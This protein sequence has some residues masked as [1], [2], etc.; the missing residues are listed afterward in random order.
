MNLNREIIDCEMKN[1]YTF[2]S[3][4]ALILADILDV[5][6]NQSPYSKGLSTSRRI[7]VASKNKQ[8]SMVG[9]SRKLANRTGLFLAI[10][11]VGLIVTI[12]VAG[13]SDGPLVPAVP[14][15]VVD[16][17]VLQD[18]FKSEMAFIMADSRI[19]AE[20]LKRI[21]NIGALNVEGRLEFRIQQQPFTTPVNNIAWAILN[22]AKPVIVV[23][24]PH[25]MHLLQS[26]P[27]DVFRSTLVITLVHER[28]H[29]DNWPRKQ[30][31]TT[32]ELLEEEIRAYSGM[33]VE[34]VR[35][36]RAVGWP[37]LTDYV[38][39]EKAFSDCGDNPQCPQ[40][41]ELIAELID[42]SKSRNRRS[43]K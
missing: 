7:H 6:C 17:Q 2:Q 15:E 31:F 37:V 27:R 38:D 43:K 24:G 11:T 18:T 4:G 13:M 26:Y 1:S 12:Y 25:F 35:P 33:V 8:R 42:A 29:L 14:P 40:F 41:R 21:R 39:V 9:K 36:M 20:L 23:Y 3:N 16:S 32:D 5:S 22:E 28:I 34:A 30:D 10:I 19:P